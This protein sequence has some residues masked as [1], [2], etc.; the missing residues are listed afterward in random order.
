MTAPDASPPTHPSWPEGAPTSPPPGASGV[1]AVDGNRAALSLLVLQNVVAALG[2]GMDLPIGGRTVHIGLHL[3]LGNALLLAFAVVVLVAFTVFR[4]AMRSL[5]RDS[6]WRTRPSWG[7][8]LAAFVLGFLASRAFAL[9]YVSFFPDSINAMPR[10]LSSGADLIPLL[11]SAGLLVPLAEEVAFRGLMM[12]GQERAAGFTVAALATS[13]AFAVAH[14]VPASVAGILPLAYVLARLAQ[15]SG[16]LWNSVI[17]H[18]L[19]NSLS[20]GLG[21][22]LAGQNLGGADQAGA[23]LG[24]SG[25]ALPLAIGALLFGVAVLVVL[26]LW[27]VPRADAQVRSAPGPWLSGAYVVIVVFGVLTML[28]T[29][30][31]VQQLTGRL[32][33]ALP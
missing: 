33:G 5:L 10:F 2:V 20:I 4:P 15:H 12:R 27:L 30:P 7:L 13:L 19:N 25:L 11:L 24:N 29:L 18:A 9:A 17:V 16:S 32:S 28:A 23:L 6:R 22:L 3:S 14:G 8:A 26:H 21:S 31:A 1:R